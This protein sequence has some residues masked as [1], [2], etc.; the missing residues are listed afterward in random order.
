MSRA[1]TRSQTDGSRATRSPRPSDAAGSVALISGTAWPTKRT[2]RNPAP[3]E[4]YGSM[5]EVEPDD[6]RRKVSCAIPDMYSNSP[7]RSKRWPKLPSPTGSSVA[8]E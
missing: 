8:G 5:S 2:R 3:S 1:S 6:R 4:A 7:S